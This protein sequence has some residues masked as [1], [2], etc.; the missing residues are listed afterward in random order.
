MNRTKIFIVTVFIIIF[1][2]SIVGAIQSRDFEHLTTENGL[3]NSV[4][5][6][7][8]Q[9][10]IGFMWF[11]TEGGL[12][13]YD[14]YNFT[15]Y[16][17]NPHDKNSLAVNSISLL[18][19][20]R[21]GIIW[22][23]S[24]GGGLIAF[25]PNT[26]KFLNFF[27][28]PNDS[29]SI[30]ENLIQ[31]IFEDK[32]GNLWVGTYGS[33]L[34]K[35][36]Q[37]NRKVL[38]WTKDDLTNV[39]LSFTR[40]KAKPDDPT[41]ISNNRI[42]SIT[43]DNDGNLWIATNH[44][45]SKLDTRT[46]RFTH[47]KHDPANKNSISDNQVRK[48]YID[49]TGTL[50]VC[51]QDGLN[52]YISETN[53]F[54]RY[55]I[56]EAKSPQHESS[57]ITTIC[58]DRS[59]YFWVGTEK[60]G[61][62]RFNRFTKGFES[63]AHDP[64]NPK[65]LS[66]DNIRDIYEDQS[67]ILWIATRGGGINKIDIKPK[68]F[69]HVEYNLTKPY[70]LN[71]PT[72]T[73]IYEDETQLVWIGTDGGGLNVIERDELGNVSGISYFTNDPNDPASISN[74]RIRALCTDHEGYL[75]VG[76]YRFGLNRV[77]L[78]SYPKAGQHYRRESLGKKLKFERIQYSPENP[79]GLSNDIIRVI[80]RDRD[81]S[82]WIGTDEGLNVITSEKITEAK[83]SKKPFDFIHYKYIPGD[84]TSLYQ[85]TVLSVL[86]DQTGTIW[87][88]SMGGGLSKIVAKPNA[89]FAK[90]ND[91]Y[92]VHYVHDPADSN[93]I[94]NNDVF[95]IYEDSQKRL[96]IGTNGGLNEFDS[97]TNVFK[98]YYE[99]D[100][101]PSNEIK[102]ILEDN[103]GNLW[104]STV[105]GLSKF[106]PRTK[107]FKNYDVMDGL[108]E[109]VF[110][111]NA[112]FKSNRIG[113]NEMFFGGVNGMNIFIPEKVNI[114][115]HIPPIVITKFYKN[116]R[117][118]TFSMAIH[119]IDMIELSYQD[120]FAFEFAALDYTNSRKNQYKY[121]LEG[122]DKDW[123]V[124]E[125]RQYASYTNLDGGTYVFR[126]QG[127][128]NDGT[129]NQV[130]A[131]VTIIIDPPF[132]K[133]WWFYLFEVIILIG[134]VMSIVVI[135]RKRLQKEMEFKRKTEELER[136]RSIQTSLVP[137]NP[138]VLPDLTMFGYMATAKE[139]GGDYFDFIQYD[140]NK[141]VYIAIGDVSGKGV[142]AS[143]LMVEVRTIFHTLA[144]EDLATKEILIRT[145]QQLYPDLSQMKNPMFITLLLIAWNSQTKRL[146]YTGAGHER[147]LV[148]HEKDKT[149]DAIKTGGVCLGV[150]D[151]IEYILVEKSLSLEHGDTVLLYTD[152]ITEY[153][154]PNEEMYGLERLKNYFHQNGEKSPQDIVNNLIKELT[155]FGKGTPQI[156]DVT[157]IVFKKT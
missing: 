120:R 72:V 64:T 95:A 43:E 29:T 134:I 128:N 57:I 106:N 123:R 144:Q 101:L 124:S 3:P 122:F 39:K 117:P 21:S 115:L 10:Q 141:N 35:L 36:P 59:G 136:A 19:Q 126:V 6:S 93:S 8:I 34:C 23:A 149:I 45:L 84:D 52:R 119:K 110:Y 82:I 108:Q 142:P 14:G 68:K 85:G 153:V 54:E 78:N 24:W 152:G 92:F 99:R 60:N 135:Q 58:E 146:T 145:N 17:S 154:G 86:Q 140:K 137:K 61:I 67:G 80:Y 147:I 90:H 151:S 44:Y 30:S 133:T 139:V 76:T 47:Y 75:W 130:G 113:E 73:S 50:W 116:D 46:D 100:G 104:V 109:N 96:W 79:K 38:D 148:Y 31:S 27:Y 63:Y 121:K 12:I 4:V 89:D 97:K 132:W 150:V 143:L 62:Y 125:N 16:R 66:H 111:H 118:M 56:S 71:N 51:S 25:N 40:F 83:N 20:D 13:R 112:Y 70:S 28:D 11:G 53:S 65:S 88:G 77:N 7:I 69:Q 129:W 138:P 22:I 81:N 74:N 107:T 103:E 41:T 42:W 102:G 91:N 127:T 26:G 114:N 18:Y 98:R 155:G 49:H 55:Y 1:F 5:F 32:A 9:D 156:D 15:T 131:S 105:I 37:A 2:A 157:M 48:V 33:G 94:S 87:I